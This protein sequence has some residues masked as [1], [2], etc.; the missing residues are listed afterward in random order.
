[1]QGPTFPTLRAAGEY[2]LANVRA[3]MAAKC[4]IYRVIGQNTYQ[5]DH[6][7]VRLSAI[8]YGVVLMDSAGRR[9]EE[10]VA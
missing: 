4:R 2:G 8:R 3:G 6:P 7:G 1:M 5:Q 10:H 9:I